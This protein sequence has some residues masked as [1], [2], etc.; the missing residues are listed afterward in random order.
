MLIYNI[1]VRKPWGKPHLKYLCAHLIITVQWFLT[2]FR[3]C[4]S[5]SYCWLVQLNKIQPLLEHLTS[6]SMIRLSRTTFLL[7]VRHLVICHAV[8]VSSWT[9]D[10]HANT[11]AVTNNINNTLSVDIS[12]KYNKNSDWTCHH[13]CR[14]GGKRHISAPPPHPLNPD[15]RKKLTLKNKEISKY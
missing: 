14:E 3:G 6:W 7:G 13:V 11:F 4:G 2:R 12:N 1:L 9:Q 5:V 15:F 10:A 8:A